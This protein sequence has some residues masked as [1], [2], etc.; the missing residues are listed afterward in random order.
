MNPKS[1]AKKLGISSTRSLS[2]CKITVLRSQ[3][4]TKALKK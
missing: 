2:N 4:R 1:S 3:T